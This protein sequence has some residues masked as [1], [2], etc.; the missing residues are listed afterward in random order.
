M[1]EQTRRD[2]IS[3]MAAV[4]YEADRQ[5]ANG[6]KA[7][8]TT[9]PGTPIEVVAEAWSIAS[10]RATDEWWRQVEATID[11]EAVRKAVL[12]IAEQPGDQA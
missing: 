10:D 8:E 9:F 3:A 1:T 11:G 2:V 5:G 12:A 7:I 4:G 6:W